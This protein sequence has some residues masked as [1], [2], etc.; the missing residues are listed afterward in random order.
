MT[1]SDTK[2]GLPDACPDV[3]D[4]DEIMLSMESK[5]MDIEMVIRNM[6]RAQ[7]VSMSM[8]QPVQHLL[9]SHL[10]LNSFSQRPTM[11]NYTVSM[12][13]L[14]K[15]A[16]AVFG[17]A[18]VAIGA[19]ISKIIMWIIG[20]FKSNDS[21]SQSASKAA[22]QL[23]ESLKKS[24][25]IDKILTPEIKRDYEER[26]AEKL[27]PIYDE[28]AQLYNG[29]LRDIL[30]VGPITRCL[31]AADKTFI[32]VVK[33][34]NLMIDLI[35]KEGSKD[36]SKDD[37]AVSRVLSTLNDIEIR[38]DDPVIRDTFSVIH[39]VTTTE[40]NYQ[41][42]MREITDHMNS[43]IAQA[44]SASFQGDKVVKQLDGYSVDKCP[45]RSVKQPGQ[46]EGLLK[47]VA[48]LEKSSFN[49]KVGVD[50]DKA[51]RKCL[52][53]MRKMID[54]VQKYD[55]LIAKCERMRN[56][57]VELSKRAAAFN[58]NAMVAAIAASDDSAV[59]DKLR[60]INKKK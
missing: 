33:K 6:Q 52:A 58:T 7:G 59:K 36:N 4:E 19:L 48:K 1:L 23:S 31:A 42:D 18:V 53:S 2:T 26:V 39:R 38:I 45:L 32:D 50:V 34:M 22:E 10:K 12:E 17:G 20:L 29:V 40:V 5:A 28:M 60:E 3:M 27:K 14:I 57:F 16:T 43:L 41:E 11:T 24:E 21:A 25:Q 55:T 44:Y 46:L 35:K 56:H 8:V 37:H 51:L 54:I 9:P 13:G 49:P 15:G 47:Q 30:E